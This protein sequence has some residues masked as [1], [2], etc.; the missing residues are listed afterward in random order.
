MV[1]SSSY[2][3]V[4][5]QGTLNIVPDVIRLEIGL[6]MTF[7]SYEEAYKEGRDNNE[8]I[9]RILEENGQDVDLGHT[10]DFDLTEVKARQIDDAGTMKSVAGKMVYKL[11]QKIRIDL[12]IDETLTSNIV[13]SIGE[14]L[15]GVHIDI[16]FTLKNL[17][18]TQLDLLEKAV[19]D[20][21]IKAKIMAEAAGCML[22]NVS[23]INYRMEKPEIYRQVRTIHSNEEAKSNTPGSLLIR[24]ADFTISDTVEVS[25]HLK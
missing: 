23:K 24:P 1:D 22:G 20:A 6:S 14:K 12:P 15:R 17:Q 19:S 3:T 7:N 16:G 25:W 4:Q 9:A 10:I 11:N 18:Q 13:R 21:L 8:W 5:G 2:I